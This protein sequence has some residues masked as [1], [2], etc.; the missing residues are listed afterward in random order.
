[1]L[2]LHAPDF[3]LVVGCMCAALHLAHRKAAQGSL[4]RERALFARVLH[5]NERPRRACGKLA[6]TH[7]VLHAVVQIQKAQRIC[8]GRAA[9]REALC[10]FFL[11][12]VVL[13]HQETNGCRFLDGVQVFALQVFN[14]RNFHH[15]CIVERFDDHR[16]LRKP[17]KA[18]RAEAAFPRDDHKT[19]AV[20]PHDDRLH[21]AVPRDAVR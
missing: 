11:R 4:L 15:L 14:E 21:H 16:N 18:R 9:F 7:I 13:F 1:M 20:L 3:F 5:G 8:N 10:H 2:G 6:L 17:C 12:K 19:F